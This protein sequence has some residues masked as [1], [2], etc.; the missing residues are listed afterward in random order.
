MVYLPGL[1]LLIYL[2]IAARPVSLEDFQL[3]RSL[4]ET[5]N[6]YFPAFFLTLPVVF[7]VCLQTINLLLYEILFLKPAK[8]NL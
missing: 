4:L 1:R 5:H 8:K 6:V 3:I 2:F 7:T